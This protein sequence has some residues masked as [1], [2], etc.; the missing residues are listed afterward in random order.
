[1]TKT[2]SELRSQERGQPLIYTQVALMG[3][4]I[5]QIQKDVGTLSSDVK[6][7]ASQRFVTQ[8]EVDLKI[9]QLQKEIAEEVL[10]AKTEL[11]TGVRPFKVLGTAVNTAIILAILA[12]IMQQILK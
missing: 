7:L 5:A 1:M 3:K 9:A 4:D 2:N 12:A 11:E 10:K 8:N 6:V